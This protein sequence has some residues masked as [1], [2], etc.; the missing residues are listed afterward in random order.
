[1]PSLPSCRSQRMAPSSIVIV[2]DACTVSSGV[3]SDGTE[4]TRAE[5]PT[6]PSW[7]RSFER[8]VDGRLGSHVAIALPGVRPTALS[9]PAP[10]LGHGE[11]EAG[12]SG[13]H[14]SRFRQPQQSS[15]VTPNAPPPRRR[16]VVE[17]TYTPSSLGL[18]L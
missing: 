7:S 11:H 13:E 3:G 18:C 4:T 1:M 10:S 12:S 14:C 5:Q 17:T 15:P 2:S 16:P 6:P 9:A 8:A